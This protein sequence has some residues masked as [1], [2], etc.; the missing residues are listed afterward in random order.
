MTQETLFIADLQ[1]V[2]SF[3]LDCKCGAAKSYNP[4]AQFFLNERCHQCGQD[5]MDASTKEIVSDLAY[6]L[7]KVR[8]LKNSNFAMRLVFKQED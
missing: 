5:M 4:N 3:R 6:A 2:K 1:D 7:Q 8:A